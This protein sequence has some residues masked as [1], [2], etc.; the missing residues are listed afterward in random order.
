MDPKISSKYLDEQGEV[1]REE[2]IKLALETK[3]TEFHVGEFT[4]SSGPVKSSQDEENTK[5][6]PARS[7]LLCCVTE[8]ELTSAKS[9]ALQRTASVE[10]MKKIER[11]FRKFDLNGD[12]FLS[13]E[14]FV[15]VRQNYNYIIFFKI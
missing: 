6:P 11:A 10:R 1:S 13:W 5:A 14:E 7:N 12:G 4:K 9:P 2:F 3:L 8:P 15:Q